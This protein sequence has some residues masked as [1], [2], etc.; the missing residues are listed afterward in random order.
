MQATT[1]SRKLDT[2]GRIMIPVRLREQ[3]GLK[4]GQEYQF[5]LYE[6]D[7]HRFICIECPGNDAKIEEAFVTLRQ[8]GYTV[9]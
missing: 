5:F 7:G 4:A 3:L 2:M 8:A 9:T 6:E 1:F